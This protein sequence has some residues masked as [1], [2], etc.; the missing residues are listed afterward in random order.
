MLTKKDLTLIGEEV[1]RVIEDNII[2]AMDT[3]MEEKFEKKLAPIKAEI[4]EMKATMATKDF[5]S[6][7]VGELRGDMSLG[8]RKMEARTDELVMVLKEK[9]VIAPTDAAYQ[10][11]GGANL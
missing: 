1:G 5:V 4:A 7:K 10:G 6:E 2:P 3:M 11:V 9:A 8:F